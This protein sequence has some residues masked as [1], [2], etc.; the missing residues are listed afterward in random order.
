MDE[1]GVYFASDISG[2]HFGQYRYDVIHPVTGKAVKQPASGWRYPESTMLERIKQE[3]VH[4][5]KDET[6]VPC[7]KTYLIDTV[8]QNVGSVKYKDGRAASKK[9][10]AL[11]GTNCFTNPKDSELLSTLF[12]SIGLN[13][14]DIILDFF[15]GPGTTGETVM[16]I[17]LS[18]GLD[19]HFLFVQVAEDLDRSLDKATGSTKQVLNNAISLCDSLNSPDRKSNV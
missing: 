13:N 10:T 8:N 19:I 15:S 14:G 1:R 12:K 17:A 11:M 3:V 5:G 4:F 2:P 7:N 9:L 6:K 18:T 16:N